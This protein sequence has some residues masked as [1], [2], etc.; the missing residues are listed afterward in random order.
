[1]VCLSTQVIVAHQVGRIQLTTTFFRRQ[2]T[3][4]S[5]ESRSYAGQRTSNGRPRWLSWSP[6]ASEP[7]ASVAGVRCTGVMWSYRRV[8]VTSRDIA[9]RGGQV[10]RGPK[11]AELSAVRNFGCLDGEMAWSTYCWRATE[12]RAMSG[13]VVTMCIVQ[14]FGEWSATWWTNYI[15]PC[16]SGYRWMA[17]GLRRVKMLG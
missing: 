17:F 16:L 11:A 2:L 7:E 10:V 5:Q 3:V 13:L 1:M 8:P 9:S 12:V 14:S 6:P 15:S 4:S